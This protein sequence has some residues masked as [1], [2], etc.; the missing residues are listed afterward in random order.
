[1]QTPGSDNLPKFSQ[2]EETNSP[3][4][5]K[6]NEQAEAN[7]R[8]ATS[9]KNQENISESHA[10]AKPGKTGSAGPEEKDITD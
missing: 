3:D 5:I 8:D 7:K 10:N 1:M 6:S 2:E 9:A 4:I